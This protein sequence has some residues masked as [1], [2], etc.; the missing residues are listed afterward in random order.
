MGCDYYLVTEAIVTCKDGK[1]Y[2][3]ILDRE[4]RYIMGRDFGDP[5]DFGTRER[6]DAYYSSIYD[7]HEKMTI[8]KNPIVDDEAV[9][10]SA[11]ASASVVADADV[12]AAVPSD[13]DSDT[14]DETDDDRAYDDGWCIPRD[15]ISVYM[16]ILKTIHTEFGP[17]KVYVDWSDEWITEHDY[18]TIPIK[19]RD[20]VTIKKVKYHEGR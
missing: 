13:Y 10:A 1:E 8:F 6:E 18:T 15:R 16:E 19:L 2:T 7:H 14:D 12:A 17:K 11:A 3:K 20:V 5:D 9:V 4:P